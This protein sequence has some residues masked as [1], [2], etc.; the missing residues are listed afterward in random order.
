MQ[1]EGEVVGL[2]T[3]DL[4]G[5][6]VPDDDCAVASELPLVHSLELA[7]RHSDIVAEYPASVRSGRTWNELADEGSPDVE[8]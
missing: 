3:Q 5:A 7:R 1:R 2:F 6:L 8:G 4:G